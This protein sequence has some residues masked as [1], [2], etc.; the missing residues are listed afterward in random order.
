MEEK[1]LD[2][3]QKA[4]PNSTAIL[5]LGICSIVL[6]FCYFCFGFLGI[7]CGIIALVLAKGDNKLYLENPEKYTEGSYSN[8]KAGKICAIVG[9]SMS[10]LYLLFIGIYFLLVFAG[11]FGNEI[12][13]N[14]LSI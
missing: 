12:Y 3:S 4:L 9:L 7:T 6:C 14:F 11:V 5:I 1:V 8:L 13:E 2:S 10:S